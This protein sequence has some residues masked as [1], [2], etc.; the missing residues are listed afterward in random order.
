MKQILSH[1]LAYNFLQNLLSKKKSRGLLIEKYVKPNK[2]DHI[3]DLGCGPGRLIDSLPKGI[4]YTG[5]DLS[6]DYIEDAK[7]R[8]G[9]KYNFICNNILGVNFSNLGFFNIVIASGFFHHIDNKTINQLLMNLKHCTNNQSKLVSIDPC[10]VDNQNWISKLLVS[11]D[12]GNYVRNKT[13]YVKNLKKH[14]NEVEAF[15][16]DDLL[17]IPYNHCICIC[18]EIR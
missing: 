12:R 16:H 10:F 11:N 14:F 17:R 1:P 7:L 6:T 5:I 18:S 2:K 9:N 8:Y 13:D 15:M 3:L 4:Q